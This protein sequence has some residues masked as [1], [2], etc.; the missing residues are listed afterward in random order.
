MAWQARLAALL[1]LAAHASASVAFQCGAVGLAAQDGEPIL[2]KMPHVIIDASGGCPRTYERMQCSEMS[3]Q[4]RGGFEQR[5]TIAR[6]SI[7]ENH[8]QHAYTRGH[9]QSLGSSSHVQPSNQPKMHEE[10]QRRLTSNRGRGL[11]HMRVCGLLSCF[12]GTGRRFRRRRRLRD[13]F[14]GWRWRSFARLLGR[15]C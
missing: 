2:H 8:D 14:R 7:R 10:R 13:H 11:V 12:R 1:V 6:L 5:S 9:L 4:M 3:Q 15:R